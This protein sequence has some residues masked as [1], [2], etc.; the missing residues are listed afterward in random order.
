MHDTTIVNL[1]ALRDVY[2]LVIWSRVQQ[3]ALGRDASTLRRLEADLADALP[4][5]LGE[6]A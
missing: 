5:E 1:D 6:A 2:L 4:A 3:E